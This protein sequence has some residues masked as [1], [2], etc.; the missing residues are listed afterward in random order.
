MKTLPLIVSFCVP[1]AAV[2]VVAQKITDSDGRAAAVIAV[3]YPS[4]L[5]RP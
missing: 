3:I 5:R 1:G 2:F 4:Q